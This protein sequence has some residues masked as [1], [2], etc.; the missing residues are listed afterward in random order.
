MVIRVLTKGKTL[1]SDEIQR[2]SSGKTG[3][4]KDKKKIRSN[5]W[6]LHKEGKKKQQRKIQGP[7]R[8]EKTKNSKDTQTLFGPNYSGALF[9]AL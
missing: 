6:I 3:E 9:C 2:G 1:K 8:Q 4:E 7:A 5:L